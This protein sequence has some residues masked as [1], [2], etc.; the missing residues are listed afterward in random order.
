[1][2]WICATSSWEI[3]SSAGVNAE[4]GR[5]SV[6]YIFRAIDLAL[7]GE[8]DA[9]VTGP[10]NKEAMNAAGFH[11]A[12]HTEIFAQ[13]TG[14]KEYAMLLVDGEMRVVHVSTH[15]S[16][17]EACE[18][19]KKERV[20]TVIRLAAEAMKALDISRPKIAVAGLNPH[21]ER[22]ACSVGKKSRKLFQLW[23]RPVLRGLE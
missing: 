2:C 8:L 20:L 17:R 11:Y 21:A 7:A 22:M 3:S 13:R 19:V 12:G 1:M 4:A 10:I 16:L 23:R 18:L 6:E 5:A 9:V 14:A 15:V